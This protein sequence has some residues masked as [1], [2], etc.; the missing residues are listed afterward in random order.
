MILINANDNY[1]LR[2]FKGEMFNEFTQWYTNCRIT[3][4]LTNCRY[5]DKRKFRIDF[6]LTGE[7]YA[8]LFHKLKSKLNFILLEQCQVALV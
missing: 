3:N 6:I 4:P 8:T 2:K 7:K 1:W 5:V